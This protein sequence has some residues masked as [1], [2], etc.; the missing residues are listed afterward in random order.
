[1][2]GV[3][4]R[5]RDRKRERET[6]G[7]REIQGCE[8]ERREERGERQTEGVGGRGQTGRER[9]RVPGCAARERSVIDVMAVYLS[10]CGAPQPNDWA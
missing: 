5:L 10:R 7:L 4:E 8:R 9:G 1:M 6:E 3:R 2:Q